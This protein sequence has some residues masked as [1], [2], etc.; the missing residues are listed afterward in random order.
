MNQVSRL[1][2]GAILFM[3]V[4]QASA[5]PTSCEDPSPLRFSLV[6]RTDLAKLLDEYRP[7]LSLMEGTLGRK[8]IVIH[9]SSYGA[10]VE[11]LVA[12]TIDVASMGPAS[13][14]IARNRD[15][16]IVPFVTWTMQG[17]TFVK[18]GA[19]FYHSLLITRSARNFKEVT[20]LKGLSVS[21][22]D[23]AST[24]G[25]VIPR[26]ELRTLTGM[27]LEEFFGQVTYSGSHDRSI[28][29]VKK[30]YTDAAFVASEHLDDAIRQNRIDAR[31]LRVIWQSS[32]IPHDPFVYRGKLCQP[33]RDKI[34]QIFLTDS[35]EIRKLLTNLKA[36]RF[37]PVT[38]MDFRQLQELLTREVR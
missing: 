17:G 34:R 26:E 7:L 21:L 24:S 29:S 33:L 6:P 28:E 11:G 22:T 35:P 2:L 5:A 8:V 36:D 13:Y 23:P 10:V 37:V 19:H 38:E 16:S 18:A 25:A 12:G 27:R 31:E 1:L 4:L 3:S 14:S 15:P 32:P 9:P 30:G 20:A